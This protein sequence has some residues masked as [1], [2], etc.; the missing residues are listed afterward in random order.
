MK[1]TSQAIHPGQ[2]IPAIYSCDGE[3]RS[4][5]LVWD[6]VPTNTRSLALIVDDPDAPRGGQGPR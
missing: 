1:L 5:A 6:D 2:P 3:N 4:P